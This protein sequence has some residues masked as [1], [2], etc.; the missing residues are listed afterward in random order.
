MFLGNIPCSIRVTI[1]LKGLQSPFTHNWFLTT[2]QRP[3]PA[4][5][6][7][8]HFHYENQ[9]YYLIGSQ[10]FEQP[11]RKRD[12]NLYVIEEESI[13]LYYRP[14]MPNLAVQWVGKELY[15]QPTTVSS[16]WLCLR[17]WP[18][19]FHGTRYIVL[20]WG[21]ST[22]LPRLANRRGVTYCYSYQGV[23]QRLLWVEYQFLSITLS[24]AT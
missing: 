5:F 14:C 8:S 15:R 17:I 9:L 4:F 22:V 19:A 16:R 23:H 10:Y 1:L 11:L 3:S 18:A 21:M 7:I 2:R 13:T 24:F 12:H 6:D 20:L